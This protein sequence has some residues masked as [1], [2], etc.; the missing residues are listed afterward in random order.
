MRYMTNYH[1]SLHNVD[2][3]AG[4]SST[5]RKILHTRYILVL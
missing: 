1:V 3:A 4:Y 5:T 2:A